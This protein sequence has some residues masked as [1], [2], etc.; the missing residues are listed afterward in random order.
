MPPGRR[1]GPVRIFIRKKVRPG[2]GVMTGWKGAANAFA[3]HI[4]KSVDEKNQQFAYKNDILSIK[5][6]IQR[7][8][9]YKI[10]KKN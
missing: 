1:P 7:E 9:W 5:N 3:S 4:S 10:D 8:L 6:K 2:S